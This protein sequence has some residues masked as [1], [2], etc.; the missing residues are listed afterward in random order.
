MRF[1]SMVWQKPHSAAWV[2]FLASGI[3]KIVYLQSLLRD[4]Q[5]YLVAIVASLG[6]LLIVSSAA[7]VF[8]GRKRIFS[9]AVLDALLTLL[10]VANVLLYRYDG[11]F[12]S[13][14][15]LHQLQAILPLRAS[16]AY[17]WR[18]ADSIVLVGLPV[19]IALA[20]SPHSASGSSQFLKRLPAIVVIAAT[21]F[22][23]FYTAYLQV[24]TPRRLPRSPFYRIGQ[25]GI[26]GFHLYDA[27]NYIPAS[28]DW[29]GALSE[30]DF[31]SIEELFDRPRTG[32][33]AYAGISKGKNLIIVQVEALQS[34]VLGKS[35]NGREITPNLNALMSESVTFPRVRYMTRGGGTA[36]VEFQVQTSLYPTAGPVYLRYYKNYY[37]GALPILLKKAGYATYALHAFYPGFWNRALMYEALGFD[38]FFSRYDYAQE[39]HLGWGLDDRSFFTQSLKLIDTTRP[40]YAFFITLSSHF[41][42]KSFRESSVSELNVHPYQHALLGDY[43]RAMNYV[44]A[45]LGDFISDLK[46]RGLYE[47][48][49]LVVYGDHRGIKN[50]YTGK[51][52][53][54]LYQ[55]LALQEESISRYTHNVTTRTIPL[56]LHADG[57]PEGKIYSLMGSQIDILPTIANLMGLDAAYVI[58]KDLLNAEDGYAVIDD[59]TILID[60]RILTRNKKRG[61]VALDQ[62]GTRQNVTADWQDIADTLIDQYRTSEIII[63]KNAF[64]KTD[65]E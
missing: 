40:F 58:G 56:F 16:I 7:F 63:R 31:A 30:H 38:R 12:V 13:I 39:G 8:V 52:Y 4:Q 32:N 49:L 18:F 19:L 47:N 23:M 17:L 46:R 27:A 3:V 26:F 59:A 53:G 21:G 51:E 37:P 36:N 34:F 6:A 2:V 11:G 65:I 15:L 41:P 9:L 29:G 61:W 57:L 64:K 33:S 35:I 54:D 22:L 5:P 28:L 55:F 42:F 14:S 43:L 1:L 48:S 20:L 10:T 60:D 62:N 45:A 44:D 50:K 24:Q 25:L